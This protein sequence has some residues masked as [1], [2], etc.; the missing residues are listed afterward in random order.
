MFQYGYII[1]T[2]FSIRISRRSVC[3]FRGSWRINVMSEHNNGA[4]H[5]HESFPEH[6]G[7]PPGRAWRGVKP[8]ALLQQTIRVHTADNAIFSVWNQKN[9]PTD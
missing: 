3:S 7:V 5:F 9:A 1:S 4:P 6:T 8:S 2:S